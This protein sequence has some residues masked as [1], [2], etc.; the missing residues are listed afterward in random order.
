ME[1]VKDKRG[2]TRKINKGKRDTDKSNEK[3]LLKKE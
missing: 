3:K 2:K 1:K